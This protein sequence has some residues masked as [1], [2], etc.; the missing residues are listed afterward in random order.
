MER[1]VASSNL[2]F[3]VTADKFLP[4]SDTSRKDNE[5]SVCIKSKIAV[6]CYS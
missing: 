4:L 1:A 6:S 2:V 5:L 3:M